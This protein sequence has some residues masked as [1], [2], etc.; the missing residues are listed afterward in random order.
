[1]SKKFTIIIAIFWLVFLGGMIFQK[2]L[3]LKNGTEVTLQTQPV[4]PRDLFRGDYVILNYKDLSQVV[5]NRNLFERD[6]TVY[7]T[8]IKN[9]E[10]QH[11]Y[12]KIFGE[13]PTE[14]LFIRGKVEYS[15]PTQNN[16]SSTYYITYGIEKY[17]VP[18]NRGKEIEN[19]STTVLGA[20]G[21]YYLEPADID[22]V[23]SISK[24]GAAQVKSLIIDGEKLEF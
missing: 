14:G 1:M 16:N 19:K 12:S 9:R 23:I 3:N 15:S 11:Q 2:E 18:E 8:L 17:F 5:G 7:V 10:G 21:S 20:D 4:D 6:Q 13:K 22:A 24:N